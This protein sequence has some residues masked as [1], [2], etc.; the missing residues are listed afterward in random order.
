MSIN[1]DQTAINAKARLH[2]VSKRTHLG[3]LQTFYISRLFKH[4]AITALGSTAP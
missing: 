4:N 3:K 1:T 2:M